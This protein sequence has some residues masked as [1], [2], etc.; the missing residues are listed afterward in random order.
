MDEQNV[1]F[2]H[3]ADRVFTLENGRMEFEDS[4]QALPDDD[5]L[6]RSHFGLG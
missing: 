1:A 5:A 4:V 6:H 2:L 3:L